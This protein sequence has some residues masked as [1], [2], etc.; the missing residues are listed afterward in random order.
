MNSK[1]IRKQL[2]AAVAMVLVAAVALGSSTYAWFVNNN[3]VTANLNNVSATAASASLYIKQGKQ[4]TVP[5][6]NLTT[7]TA[8][9]SLSLVPVSNN[10][11]NG[12][13]GEWFTVNKWENANA[14]GYAQLSGTNK[15]AAYDYQESKSGDTLT[16]ATIK[17]SADNN[18]R[19]GAY[20]VGEYTLYTATSNQD[21]YLDPTEPIIVTEGTL[22]NGTANL[23]KAIRIAIVATSGNETK[24]LYYL[25]V[26][27]TKAG[28][29]KI[30][31]ATGTGSN[32]VYGVSSATGITEISA[33]TDTSSAG[34]FIPDTEGVKSLGNWTATAVGN[35][36]YSAGTFKLGTAGNTADTMMD[37]KVYVWLEG[38]DGECLINE[39]V[40]G[41]S[42]LK[43]SVNFVGVEPTT[44]G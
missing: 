42:G 44:T 6:D 12:S 1:A 13:L 32:K 24:T 34:Y 25:P 28:N 22:A 14:T 33:G 23:T 37:V 43:V 3:K 30:S 21:V 39:G 8:S 40:D 2:L 29:D 41:V 5:N 18:T 19:V 27:E 26:A 38:T 9:N 16:G 31:G 20:V 35:G 4:S 10:F 11:S 17:M 7:D 15:V 36:S